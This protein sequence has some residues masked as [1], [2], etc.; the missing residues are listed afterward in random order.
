MNIISKINQYLLERYPTIW[1]TKIVWMLLISLLIHIVFFVIGYVSHINPES[2]Q[3]R[4]V[5]GDYFTSGLVLAHIIISILLVVGWVVSLL[6]NN[7][8]KNF[9]PSNNFKLFGQFVQYFII[10]FLSTT[11]YF[12]YILGFE[13]FVKQNYKDED[14]A[15]KTEI[16]NVANAFLSQDPLY[17]TLNN[18][19]YP[20]VFSNLYC[21]TDR[22]KIDVNSKF[23]TFFDEIY[24]FNDLY[25]KE[26]TQK[27][28]LGRFVYPEFE[29]ENN[30]P[31]AY[32]QDY[33][34]RCV[35]YFKKNVVDVSKYVSN[36]N[37]N[38]KNFS[39]VFYAHGSGS[40]YEKYY[41]F[42]HS[43]NKKDTLDNASINKK[44]VEL[45]ERNDPKEIQKI[46][47]DFLKIS[48]DFKIKTNL[49][50]KK[51][52]E[53]IYHPASFDVKNFIN[54][55]DP[56][57]G[58]DN[59][60]DYTE[61][62]VEGAAVPAYYESEYT[63]GS[64][65]TVED[66]QLTLKREFI[67][68]RVTEYYY[69]SSD[70][71][72]L[73]QNIDD[74]KNNDIFVSYIPIFLWLAFAFSS[75]IF[76]FRITNLRSLLFSIIATGVLSLIISLLSVIFNFSIGGF[77]ESFS[78]Y[79]IFIISTIILLLSI[80]Q[81]FG[82]KLFKGILINMTVN[83]FVGYVYLILG[84]ISMHQTSACYASRKNAEIIEPCN[85]I[86]D[87]IES[88]NLSYLLLIVGF[89]FIFFYS[90]VIQKWKAS[91]E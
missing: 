39:N 12:S 17:Y 16:I 71:L 72:V 76:S 69:Y 79:L 86:L 31:L 20:E 13:Q 54:T 83:G 58:Y 56:K 48:K 19:S 15:A 2:L 51:W 44:I 89:L 88:S 77:S 43:F 22:D 62:N 38:Y 70:L 64:G 80:I 40:N 25:K 7:A 65:T 30:I 11:F 36:A 91:P 81:K 47:T 46:L 74:I 29:N 53:L 24:Q 63:G 21:E 8:F 10:L 14:M 68:E 6:K 1:N 35:F 41:D 85:T 75:V 3:Y 49:E 61:E 23:Y 87:Q 26:V 57:H 66:V 73:L 52:M 45:L 60:E 28:S 59:F 18:K 37:L 32:S 27:D 5:V 90:S 33:D 9:Y 34:N 67:K 84:I 42:E 82:S 78:L 4:N 55:D 50:D